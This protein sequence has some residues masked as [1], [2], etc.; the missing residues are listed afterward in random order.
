VRS[1]V[2][3][4]LFDGAPYRSLIL[5]MSPV[6]YTTGFDC[7]CIRRTSYRAGYTGSRIN[8]RHLQSTLEVHW[9]MC[10]QQMCC[11]HDKDLNGT[12]VDK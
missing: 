1:V 9:P 6:D 12:G 4:H 10:M 7:R 8:N 3:A 2:A 11:K 5:N